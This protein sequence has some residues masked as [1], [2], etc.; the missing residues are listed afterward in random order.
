[1]MATDVLYECLFYLEW[2]EYCDVC[3]YL[4]VP[5]RFDVYFKYHS[6]PIPT[7]FKICNHEKEYLDIFIH[8]YNKISFDDS[9]HIMI[10]KNGHINI[11]RHIITINCIIP[12]HKYRF[13]AC[14][15]GK[16]N[17]LKCIYKMT[18]ITFEQ[19][20]AD[21]C[22]AIRCGHL[23]IVK[24][25]HTY[26]MVKLD[27]ELLRIACKEG[28]LD[29]VKYLHKNGVTIS[30]RYIDDAVLYDHDDIA[31]YLLNNQTL[32]DKL[33]MNI[34]EYRH[35]SLFRRINYKILNFDI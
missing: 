4:N 26:E 10:A 19:A 16:L 33:Y 27:G 18:N 1:M 31:D 15:H 14:L 23:N 3:K 28:H 29:I 22:D 2:D 6:I 11:L 8:L 32:Y 5:Y 35:V 34:I 9:C 13:R 24:Y 17:I 30:N 25:L 21:M 7:Q 20:Y 12:Y